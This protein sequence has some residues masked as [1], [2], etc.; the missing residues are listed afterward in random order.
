MPRAR[1]ALFNGMWLSPRSFWRLTAL[2][3]ICRR[4]SGDLG[5]DAKKQEREGFELVEPRKE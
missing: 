4:I 5:S 3:K 1:A 2:E